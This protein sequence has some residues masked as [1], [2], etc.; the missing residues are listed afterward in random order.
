MAMMIFLVIYSKKVVLIVPFTTSKT[1][2]KSVLGVVEWWIWWVLREGRPEL[3]SFIRF[4]EELES[5]QQ[6]LI[7]KWRIV[8]P[9]WG[10][11]QKG[12]FPP[13]KIQPWGFFISCVCNFL[14]QNTKKNSPSPSLIKSLNVTPAFHCYNKYTSFGFQCWQKCLFSLAFSSEPPSSIS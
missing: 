4:T 10:S 5:K 9:Q 13:H 3:F 6:A 12:N 1:F 8:V 2:H 14:S 11:L 7:I